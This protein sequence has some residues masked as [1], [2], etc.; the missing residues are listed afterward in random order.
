[1][2]AEKREAYAR[3]IA[4]Q[5]ESV[6]R[7]HAGRREVTHLLSIEDA[8]KARVSI[9]WDHYRP[10]PPSKPGVTIFESYPLAELAPYI[11]WTPFFMAWELPGRYPEI[12]NYKHLG[13]QARKLF[14]DANQLLNRIIRER[15]L[16]ARAVIGLFPANSVG[17]DIEMYTDDKRSAVL[18]TVNHL[19]QQKEKSAGRNNACLSDFVAPRDSGAVDY[20]GAFAV[21]TGFGVKEFVSECERSHDDYNSIMAKALADRLAEALAERMHQR[22]RTEFWGYAKDERLTG[23]ALLKEEYAGIRPAPG[24]PAC[25]DHT[26]K[27]LLWR[28]LNVDRNIGLN[29]TESFAMFPTAAVS[30]WYFAHP[31]SH[32]FG[33][34]KINQDQVADYAVRKG[35][36]I[37]EVERWLAPN[38]FYEPDRKG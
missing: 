3:H 31:E 38:L 36:S 21:C 14:E 29:L 6:R 9:D 15:I 18:M 26:E 7:E 24:Y 20:V 2:N 10:I 27:A 11:D 5:Y 13:D 37:S 1:M 8:R 17:D 30:G 25:P 35:M 4:E 34:G 16:T 19:R 33:V 28:L 12:L 22:V 23:E 32:Y